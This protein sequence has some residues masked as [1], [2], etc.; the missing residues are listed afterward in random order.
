ME[1]AVSAF[2]IGIWIRVGVGAGSAVGVKHGY[3][4]GADSA[5]NRR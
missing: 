2:R 3:A 1:V 5:G 4:C